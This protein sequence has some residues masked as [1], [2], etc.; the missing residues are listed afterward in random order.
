M[1]YLSCHRYICFKK[2]TASSWNVS[3]RILCRVFYE[4]HLVHMNYALHCALHWT[5]CVVCNIMFMYLSFTM[6]MEDVNTK[7]DHAHVHNAPE[8][9]FTVYCTT[10]H[11]V[12][13]T[14]VTTCRSH[15]KVPDSLI[16]SDVYERCSGVVT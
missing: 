1:L 9:C 5:K 3:Q 8:L 15:T 7:S 13:D 14:T 4:M 11:F 2:C 6:I 16:I 10:T 12:L